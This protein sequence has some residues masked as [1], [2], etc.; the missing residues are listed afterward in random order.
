[1]LLLIFKRERL[2]SYSD[3][4][5][6]RSA[7]R[8]LFVVEADPGGD[9]MFGVFEAREA[10]AVDELAADRLDPEGLPSLA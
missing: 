5:T 6:P 9:L 7:S 2:A 4:G 1:L 10:A 3:D 8:S